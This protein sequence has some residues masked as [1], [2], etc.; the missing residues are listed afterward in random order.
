MIHVANTNT[1]FISKIYHLVWST[2][3]GFA[4]TAKHNVF[5]VLCWCPQQST[6]FSMPVNIFQDNMHTTRHSFHWYFNKCFEIAS[7]TSL[8]L[9][10]C[11]NTPQLKCQATFDINK[12]GV[13]YDSTIRLGREAGWKYADK[14]EQ[15]LAERSRKNKERKRVERSR[16]GQ[17]WAESSRKLQISVH[18]SRK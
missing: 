4:C 15:R 10:D 7:V 16:I 3:S 12:P 17:K 13:L 14:K 9:E 18:S 1:S 11:F 6:F 2:L 5:L 8:H